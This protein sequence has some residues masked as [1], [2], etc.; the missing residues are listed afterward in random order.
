MGDMKNN[1]LK[2]CAIFII[3]LLSAMLPCTA[4]GAGEIDLNLKARSFFY[5]LEYVGIPFRT[6]ETFFGDHISPRF[7]YHPSDSVTLTGGMLVGKA[8]GS[9]ETLDPVEPVFTFSYHMG[10]KVAFRGCTY[11]L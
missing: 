1:V 3:L 7:S 9:E 10:Q 8:Y 5:N 2:A 11:V 4:A 6:G